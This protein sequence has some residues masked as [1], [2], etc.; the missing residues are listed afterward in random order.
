MLW[1]MIDY[2][3]DNSGKLTQYVMF[4]GYHILNI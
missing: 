3:F 4:A 2:G 1:E